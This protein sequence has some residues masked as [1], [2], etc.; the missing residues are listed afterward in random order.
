MTVERVSNVDSVPAVLAT[1]RGRPSNAR[2]RWYTICFVLLHDA[3]K[4]ITWSEPHPPLVSPDK[5]WLFHLQLISFWI[6]N[7]ETL[8][9]PLLGSLLSGSWLWGMALH[10]YD[11]GFNVSKMEAFPFL[12]KLRDRYLNCQV[13]VPAPQSCRS[14]A[15]FD[16]HPI[17]WHSLK[18]R[19]GKK[20][21]WTIWPLGDMVPSR[22][23]PLSGPLISRKGC[24]RQTHPLILH[25]LCHH[26]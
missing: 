5:L 10:F 21:W 24:K 3:H 14:V 12:H 23:P 9:I 26:H 18:L 6:L 7:F 1:C 13:L 17:G 16:Q 22:T 20:I 2:N 25:W 11:V 4:A 19:F 8:D 15:I